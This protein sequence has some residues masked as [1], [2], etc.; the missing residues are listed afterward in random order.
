MRISDW[1]SD[2]CSS[3]L[4]AR[5]AAVG[6][7]RMQHVTGIDAGRAA[8]DQRNIGICRARAHGERE[9]VSKAVDEPV[10]R[11]D[12]HRCDQRA[13]QAAQALG[14]LGIA[15]GDR[16]SSLAWNTHR[17]LELFYAAPGM[18]AVLHTANPR[19]SDEQIAFTIAHAGSRILFRS[20][21]HTSELQP[22]MRISYAVFCLKKKKN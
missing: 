1:S 2:V 21:E 14:V 18:G 12:W 19:L 5:D 16:V 15:T 13:R 8:A 4:L 17:H 22:L 7:R 9:I 20:E 3:D 6:R 10:W 11:Y